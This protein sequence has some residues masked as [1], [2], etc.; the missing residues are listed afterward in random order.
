MTTKIEWVK[1][2][3][4]GAGKTWNPV[5][6]CSM[7]SPGCANCYAERMAKRLKAMGVKQYQS[8]IGDNGKWNGHITAV[9]SALDYPINIKKPTTF[10]VNSMSDLFHP[11]VPDWV[12][13]RIWLV[14]AHSP[15]H[16]FQILTKRAD[17]MYHQVNLMVKNYGVLPNVWLG[18]SAENQK[19]YDLR[20]LPL[21]NTPTAV[22]F[23]SFEP[24]LSAIDMYLTGVVPFSQ[25]YAPFGDKI[26][27]AIV[28]GESGPGARKLSLE[29]AESIY[30]QC[31]AFGVKFFMK[32]LGTALA[33]EKG[34]RGKGDKLDQLPRDLQVRE[35]PL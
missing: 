2:S 29:W 25:P 33:D 21:V 15:Q 4:G 16:T 14:M 24:L 10:F 8:V 11:N 18:V 20:V 7:A 3:D 28:G 12:I 31:R 19:Y 26:H 13:A 17:E 6:G 32:Q 23:I 30:D 34:I 27:W 22:R 1:N 9:G 5:T 35:Y